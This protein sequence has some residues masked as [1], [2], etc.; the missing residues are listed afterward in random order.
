MTRESGAEFIARMARESSLIGENGRIAWAS[1]AGL[2][3]AD[4]LRE[5]VERGWVRVEDVTLHGRTAMH[6]IAE[7]G[8]QA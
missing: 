2:V 4:D 1:L 6:I 7:N 3:T 8:E 5:A